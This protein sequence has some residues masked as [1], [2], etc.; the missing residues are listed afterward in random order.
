MAGGAPA[1][2]LRGCATCTGERRVG[3]AAPAIPGAL[4]AGRG[5]SDG[6]S[7]GQGSALREQ[8]ARLRAPFELLGWLEPRQPSARAS[9][10]PEAG[11]ASPTLSKLCP[12]GLRFDRR[13]RCYVS[14]NTS[15]RC[16]TRSELV[17]LVAQSAYLSWCGGRPTRPP[18]QRDGG[19]EAAGRG[20]ATALT[21]CVEGRAAGGALRTPAPRVCSTLTPLPDCFC[22]QKAV[23][24]RV[25]FR[26]ACLQASKKV[27][28]VRL[29]LSAST[30]HDR[31][32]W[33]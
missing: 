4:C 6:C 21:S 1:A 3:C 22:A 33:E 23:R 18:G 30:G 12:Q 15:R 24:P 28:S 19:Q 27:L 17:A 13:L 29:R 31:Q 16:Y 2:R 9:P 25:A 10:R 14:P 32:L 5:G 20:K 8:R 26:H 11:S 7:E